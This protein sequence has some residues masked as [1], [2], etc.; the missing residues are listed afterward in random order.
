MNKT[1]LA[2]LAGMLAGGAA[3]AAYQTFSTP[4]AEVVSA[5]PIT[6][7]EPIYG[8]VLAS[9]AVTEMRTGSRQVCEDVTV[10]KRR[11]ERFGNK[12]GAV[13]GAVVG[14][15][16]GNQVGGGSGKKVAT[17]AGAV[18]GG[19]AGREI[20]RRHV[21]GQRYTE[22]EQRCRTV[23][24]P[25]EEVIGYD[26]EYRDENGKIATTRVDEKP[27]DQVRLGERDKVVGYDVTWRYEDQTGSLVMDQDP[28]DRLPMRDGA[29]AVSP[30]QVAPRG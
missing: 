30:D 28:G 14:G 22:V 8:E 5:T 25:R 10:E 19:F 2:V 21:G 13:I 27:G 20:D 29:I 18:G 16:I 15:L 24:E 4:Y 7:R 12:D 1:V 17:V 9:N 11:P 23:S 6:E 3:I 26:V